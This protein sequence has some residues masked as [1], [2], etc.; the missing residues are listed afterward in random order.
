ML[1][2]TALA[3]DPLLSGIV[4]GTP[5]AD[6]SE[7]IEAPADTVVKKGPKYSVRKTDAENTD[8]LKKKTAD[9]RDPDNVQT[10]VSYDENDDT[11]TIGT[12]L[13]T[14]NGGKTGTAGSGASGTTTGN[15][16]TGNTA[17]RQGGTSTSK[18]GTG[19]AAGGSGS[20]LPSSS[21]T[22]LARVASY[23]NDPIIMTAEEYQ[24][25][26]LQQSM[27]RYFRDKNAEAFEQNG[28]DKFDFTD[29]HFDLGPAE[30]IFGP[31]GVQIKTQ[32]TAEIKMGANMKKVDN[33]SLAANRRK[34][35]G[36]D[37]DEKVNFSLNGSVGDKVKLN[38]NYDTGAEFAMNS[39]NMNLKF[40]GKEDDIVKLVQAGNV[41][42]PSNNSLIRGGSSLFGIRTDLQFGKLKVQTV[43]SQKKSASRSVSSKGGASMNTFEFSAT[44][45]EEN[46]H[47][48]LSHFFRQQYDK[49]MRSLPT[50]ASG[51]TITRIEVWVTNK[52]ATT[53]NNR[54][55]IALTDLAETSYIG[56]PLWS[57]T[58]IPVPSNK[59]NN[60]YNTLS[61]TYSGARVISQATEVLDGIGMEGSVDYEKLQ[62]ARL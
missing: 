27:Q 59:A 11:Y 34:T 8:D 46:R 33:P 39:Q 6:P 42:M 48:F 44:E 60:E 58:G 15:R 35:F 49:N 13:T 43:L 19:N 55:I 16:N 47:F 57:G 62:S 38:L 37:F 25:W 54:N 5:V 41:S 26:S 12:A 45:Y 52:S 56:S 50:I 14:G 21:L 32:G 36:F 4:Q 53:Q 51:V 10:E 23:L 61:T 7:A 40:D 9:L 28:K 30:K 29:M 18:T 1:S 22:P 3:A 2:L 24:E 20:S 31:G 17:N